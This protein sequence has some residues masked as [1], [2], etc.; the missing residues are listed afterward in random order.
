MSK[1]V[2]EFS[3]YFLDKLTNDEWKNNSLE[4]DD[5]ELLENISK[6]PLV[7]LA[8][9]IMPDAAMGAFFMAGMLWQK[10]KIDMESPLQ[11]LLKD[12]DI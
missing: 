3:E 8:I 9:M 10:Y 12:V 2:M 1:R 7:T 4:G 11:G 6:S 5:W